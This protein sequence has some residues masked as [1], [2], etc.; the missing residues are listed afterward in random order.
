MAFVPVLAALLLAGTAPAPAAQVP[1]VGASPV[2]PVA[3]PYDEAADGGAL[4]DAAVREAKAS[5]KLL[6]VEFGANWCLDCRTLAGVVRLDPVR[7]WLGR[8]YAVAAVDVGRF[9]KNRDVAAR[10]GVIITAIPTVVVATP[11]GKVLNESDETALSDARHMTPQAIV[12]LLGR[13]TAARP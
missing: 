4:V 12:D 13:W 6:L 7:A 11:D 5:G 10:Y 2:E 3:E 9:K 1:Q 8:H